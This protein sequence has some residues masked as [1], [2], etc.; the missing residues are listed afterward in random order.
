MKR[1]LTVV[2]VVAVAAAAS[3]QLSDEARLNALTRSNSLG[4]RPASSPF[5]LVDLSRMRWSHSY[6]MSFFSGGNYSGAVGLLSTT[7]FYELSPKLSF[8]LNLGIAHDAGTLWGNGSPSASLLPGFWLDY[9]PSEKFSMSL[10]VQWYKATCYPF[11][12][13]S[14]LWPRYLSPY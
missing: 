10:N 6:S 1:I 11:M 13:R 8:A 3:A 5:S 9:H 12:Y 7:M 14:H 2:L 4:V